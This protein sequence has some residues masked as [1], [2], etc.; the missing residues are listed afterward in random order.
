[1]WN[2]T[3]GHIDTTTQRCNVGF[4]GALTLPIRERRTYSLKNVEIMCNRNSATDYQ[5]GPLLF[6]N[7]VAPARDN[8]E[9]SFIMESENLINSVL[10]PMMIPTLDLVSYIELLDSSGRA[11]ATFYRY[12]LVQFCNGNYS[13]IEIMFPPVPVKTIKVKFKEDIS[14][15]SLETEVKYRSKYSAEDMADFIKRMSEYEA[16]GSIE[17][18]PKYESNAQDYYLSLLG[19]IC[20]PSLVKYERS[21]SY[22]TSIYEGAALKGSFVSIEQLHMNYKMWHKSSDNFPLTFLE[23]NLVKKN[24]DEAKT[25]TSVHYIPHPQS[26]PFAKDIYELLSSKRDSELS[27]ETYGRKSF[28]A[29]FYSSS[30]AYVYVPVIGES[31]NVWYANAN[32]SQTNDSLNRITTLT[33]SDKASNDSILFYHLD[34]HKT[35]MGAVYTQE[36]PWS[37]G[38]DGSMFHPTDAKYN[39]VGIEMLMYRVENSDEITPVVFR[40]KIG[41]YKQ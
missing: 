27:E 31:D 38:F 7:R 39:D 17:Y 15:R 40:A 20:I 30:N 2:A 4:N 41:L 6:R 26:R 8:I 12:D 33:V 22:F 3:E 21:G 9:I 1:M 11:T 35:P 29:R 25:L 10:I 14:L 24:F 36:R 34:T 16:V 37:V 28:N 18:L 13:S 32:F 23:V 19:G 5:V